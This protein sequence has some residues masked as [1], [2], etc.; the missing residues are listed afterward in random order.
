MPLT[1][2]PP[3][4]GGSAGRAERRMALRHGGI[5]T[6][7]GGSRGEP[8]REFLGA[9]EAG[10]CTV[11]PRCGWSMAAPER[12]TVQRGG[13]F[14]GFRSRQRTGGRSGRS[15]QVIGT[16]AVGQWLARVWDRRGRSAGAG[17]SC[18]SAAAAVSPCAGGGAISPPTEG[19]CGEPSPLERG[20]GDLGGDVGQGS[21]EGK[22]FS[23]S[24]RT[25]VAGKG[26]EPGGFKLWPER[27]AQRRIRQPAASSIDSAH[28]VVVFRNSE[29]VVCSIRS[30]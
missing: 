22:G 7:E 28:A 2:R 14:Q 3:G 18:E 26:Q 23:P 16:R 6:G 30:Q 4:A 10:S 8:G 19:R 9:G 29:V 12:Q 5:L 11:W 20:A 1:S 24:T 13:R 25:T 17:A 15:V 27:N 21:R